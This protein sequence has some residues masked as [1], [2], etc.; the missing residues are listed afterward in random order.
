MKS[1]TLSVQLLLLLAL[2][3]LGAALGVPGVAEQ[4]PVPS[5]SGWMFDEANAQVVITGDVD[6]TGRSSG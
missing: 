1:K 5:G 6:L 4:A 3:L 2:S